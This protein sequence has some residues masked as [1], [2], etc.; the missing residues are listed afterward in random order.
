MASASSSHA[1][2]PDPIQDLQSPASD[3]TFMELE[4]C[5]KHFPTIKVLSSNHKMPVVLVYG[6]RKHRK[7]HRYQEKGKSNKIAY[8]KEKREFLEIMGLPGKMISTAG[9]DF[10]V[11]PEIDSAGLKILY[12]PVRSRRSSAAEEERI[13]TENKENNGSVMDTVIDS[14]N[15]LTVDDENSASKSKRK[16]SP[17]NLLRKQYI[18]PH[19]KEDSAGSSKSKKKP[20]K[21]SAKKRGKR[22]KDK[23]KQPPEE[24]AEIEPLLSCDSCSSSDGVESDSDVEEQDVAVSSNYV[25]RENLQPEPFIGL[26]LT[27]IT[28]E[29]EKVGVQ[30]AR[31]L[32]SPFLRVSIRGVCVQVCSPTELSRTFVCGYPGDQLLD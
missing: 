25:H 18:E 20:K 7:E 29:L 4:D 15:K 32:T 27:Y 11:K 31:E 5:L 28:I 12:S 19:P 26:D 2:P 6:E 10:S 3:P 13:Q 17:M 24:E 9:L 23:N 14:T 21:S 22:K 16:L 1:A 30:N 8:P